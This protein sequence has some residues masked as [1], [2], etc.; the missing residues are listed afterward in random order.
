MT[1]LLFLRCLKLNCF[2]DGDKNIW[3]LY[4]ST[5][6]K[7]QLCLDEHVCTGNLE[8]FEIWSHWGQNWG[9]TVTAANQREL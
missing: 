2:R 8:D 3:N 9:Q 4:M 6:W 5:N 7:V 1:N